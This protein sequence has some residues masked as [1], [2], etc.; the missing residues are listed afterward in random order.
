MI[1]KIFILVGLLVV[2][3]IAYN[4]YQGSSVEKQNAKHEK[5]LTVKVIQVQRYTLFDELE[6]LGTAF[7]NEAVDVTANNSDK[8]AQIYFDDGQEVKKNDVLAVLEQSEEIAQKKAEEAQ[9]LE[10]KRELKRLEDLL[11]RHAAARNEYDTRKTLLSISEHRI[12][13]IEARIEDKTIRA[14]FDGVLGLRKVSVGSLVEPGSVITTIDDIDKIKLDFSVPSTYLDVVKKGLNIQAQSDAL[15]GQRFKG[16]VTNIDTRVDARTRSVVVR[17]VLPNPK[18]I[19]KPGILLTVRLFKNER[20]ALMIPEEAI[21]QIQQ[22]HFVLSVS[23]EGLVERKPINI[24]ARKPG[25]VEVLS[26]IKEGETIIVRGIS[27]VK[28]GDTVQVQ[29][30]DLSPYERD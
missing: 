2:G 9:V 26:G 25:W 24:G 14:P 10:H 21:I 4:V 18:H 5:T 13:E 28:D 7:S 8:I 16:T 22:D 20:Q 23:Q 12:D 19:I 3:F 17:A 30:L 27:R 11:E 29:R 1:K 15:R 6:A